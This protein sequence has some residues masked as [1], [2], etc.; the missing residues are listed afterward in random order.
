MEIIKADLKFKK[1]PLNILNNAHLIGKIDAV[2][3][4]FGNISSLPRFRNELLKEKIASGLF[5][6]LAMNGSE[7]S[8]EQTEQIQAGN[9]L[10]QGKKFLETEVRKILDIKQ[11]LFKEFLIEKQR[12]NFTPEFVKKMYLTATE[13]SEKKEQINFTKEQEEWVGKFFEWLEKDVLFGEMESGCKAF[14]K[15]IIIHA[16]FEWMQPFQSGNKLTSHLLEFCSLLG[17]EVPYN[18]TH[19]LPVFYYETRTEYKRNMEL[20]KTNGDMDG[21]IAYALQGVCDGLEDILRSFQV[22]QFIITWQH[23]INTTLDSD[24]G[25]GSKVTIR[26]RELM[27]A[28]PL[29]IDDGLAFEQVLILNP[30]L[31]RAYAKRT[32]TARRDLAALTELGLLIKKNKKYYP[33]VIAILGEMALKSSLVRLEQLAVHKEIKYSHHNMPKV[34]AKEL[35]SELL[36]TLNKMMG[37]DTN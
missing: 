15:A 2:L 12:L 35:K 6:F 29:D 22:Q 32:K 4:N 26:R 28:F 30:A 3:K 7:I 19:I 34:G 1:V 17:G 9:S 36:Q 23:Y 25:A 27:Q 18:A 37:R 14:I 13:N 10:P 8:L 21:F 24:E 16:Y 31:A 5:S 20:I 11:G 33:N